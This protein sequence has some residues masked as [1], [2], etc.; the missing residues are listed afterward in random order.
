MMGTRA[1]SVDPGILLRLLARRAARRRRARGRAR[2]RARA[3]WRSPAPQDMRAI[4]RGGR[5]RANADATLALAMFVR[6]AAAGIAAA[7]TSPGPPRRARVHGRHRRARRARVRARHRGAAGRPG[8]RRRPRVD[9][10]GDADAATD[11]GSGPRCAVSADR[12]ARGPR[13]RPGDRRAPRLTT[14]AA[15]GAAVRCPRRVVRRGPAR[16]PIRPPIHAR[17]HSCASAHMSMLWPW[18]P[19]TSCRPRSA[20]RLSHPLRIA[21][22]H[23]LADEPREVS[24]PRA[25]SSAS[26]SP[27][28]RSTSR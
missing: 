6:R 18:T 4:V 19:S 14:S 2:S 11:A 17:R 28:P 12:G 24:A 8:C 22:L 13:H 27:T 7:A 20:G 5:A 25:A 9:P 26:A 15:A 23:L 10:A 1:G 21:I 16:G 3:C